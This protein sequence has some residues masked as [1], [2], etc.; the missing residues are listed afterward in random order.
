MDG[1]AWMPREEVRAVRGTSPVA[2]WALGVAIVSWATAVASLGWQVWTHF[3]RPQSAVAEKHAVRRADEE[4]EALL[5]LA[6]STRPV[7]A[8]CSSYIEQFPEDAPPLYLQIRPR[9]VANRL[10]DFRQVWVEKHGVIRS[11]EAVDAYEDVGTDRVLRD[12]LA[13]P[14]SPSTDYAGLVPTVKGLRASLENLERV[15]KE[16]AR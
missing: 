4:R 1:T 7:I 6:A 11:K 15:L 8:I 3:Q 2:W 9:K 16:G 12:L 14:D 10:G 13:V 5:L